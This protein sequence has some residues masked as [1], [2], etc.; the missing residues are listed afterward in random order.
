DPFN[1]T[2]GYN[3]RG[4]I[5]HASSAT[6]SSFGYN[7]LYAEGAIYKRLGDRRATG[8]SAKVLAGHVR[9]GLVRALGSQ[10]GSQLGSDSVG[11]ILHPR[12]RFYAGGAQSVRGY[13]ESQLGPR[14][15]T[16]SR[17][18][19]S[20]MGCDVSTVEG[21]QRC[22]ANNGSV[23]EHADSAVSDEHFTP[24]PLGGTALL[25]A[26]VE[27][28][29]PILKKLTGA[30]FIDAGIV[31]SDP[32]FRSQPGL[33]D[34]SRGTGAITPGFGVRYRSPVGPI[35][36]DL[37]I[38]P[39]ISEDLPVVSEIDVNGERRV[40]RLESLRTYSTTADQKGIAKLLSRLTLHLSIGQAY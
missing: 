14:I 38:N 10:L 40:V 21:I 35:R 26:S 3:A 36:I 27:Y 31:A 4:D 25:E 22:P 6:M 16:V 15:L 30:V 7:R 37:G 23:F 5:E 18:V 2:R 12:K 39:S 9:L 11:R 28:R 34:L 20:R 8:P 24:R 1:P 13:G 17:S 19:L 29:F 33:E 32:S